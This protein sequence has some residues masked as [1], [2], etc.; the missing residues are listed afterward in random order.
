MKPQ[1]KYYIAKAINLQEQISDII[2]TE[3]NLFI[4]RHNNKRVEINGE[5]WWLLEN[6]KSIS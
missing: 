2:F 5:K 1:I 6:P 4:E 3:A